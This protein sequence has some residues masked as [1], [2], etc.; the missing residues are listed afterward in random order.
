MG[1][2]A[3]GL[4]TENFAIQNHIHPK[5]VTKNNVA[6]FKGQLHSLGYSFDWDPSADAHGTT[7]LPPGD[8]HIIGFGVSYS[9]LENWR[10]DLGYSFII[11]ESETR[12]IEVKNN[13]PPPLGNGGTSPRR[14]E[15]DNSYS[16]IISASIAYTF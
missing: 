16:H 3:F 7:M 13:V 11:M 4:P 1:W 2:D 8:R 15:C 9:F 10:V 14:F 12:M 6:R 5:M